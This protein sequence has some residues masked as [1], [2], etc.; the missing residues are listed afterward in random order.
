MSKNDRG[1]AGSQNGF[2]SNDQ[3]AD[4][5]NLSPRTL[6]K[7]RVVGGGPVFSKLGRRV[8]YAL[9]DLQ[10]WV[11]AK[12]RASTSDTRYVDAQN[13]VARGRQ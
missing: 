3:A 7:L 13:G 8:V 9:E 10:S 6:E 12:R 1:R 2:L 11:A 4:F 5:L